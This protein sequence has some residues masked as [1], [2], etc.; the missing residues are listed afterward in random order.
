[1]ERFHAADSIGQFLADNRVFMAV[2]NH[3]LEKFKKLTVVF[4]LVPVKPGDFIVLAIGIVV[5]VLGIG[6][7]IPCQEHRCPP[8]AHQNSTGVAYHAETQFQYNGVFGIALNAAVPAPVVICTVGI[9]PS[10]ILIMLFVVGIEVIESEP[11]MAGKKINTGIISCI[12]AI[13]IGIIS[14]I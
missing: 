14:A 2:G 9:V 13:V 3:K 6:K 11:V 8:A 7:F 5:A 12:I 10:I 4:K 1:M